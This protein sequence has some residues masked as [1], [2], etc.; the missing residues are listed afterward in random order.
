[1]IYLILCILISVAILVGFRLFDHFQVNRNN[2][3]ISSYL[4]SF[5]LAFLSRDSQ[6]EL[7]TLTQYDWLYSGLFIGISFYFGFQLFAISTRKIGLAITSV[8]SNMSV[9]I[10]V[11]IALIFYHEAAPFS[12]ILGLI[13]TILSFFLIFKPEKNIKL[14]LHFILY[15]LALFLLTGLNS[16]MISFADKQGA[17]NNMMIFMSTIFVSAFIFGFLSNLFS[18][19]RKKLGIRDLVAALVLGS[20]NYGSTI[21]ILKS[22]SVFPD[23]IFFPA[24]NSAYITL[25]ALAGLWFFKEKLKL[26]NW[27][28]IGLATIAIVLLTSGL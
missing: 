3:I 5:V 8:S 14:D 13:F 24:Y 7:S 12:K 28:G 22:L 6:F 27:I 21:M 19:N 23:T 20:L 15:P 18:K 1:M 11:L 10:P 16:S 2:A 25:S 17:G 4:I 9:I 26:I